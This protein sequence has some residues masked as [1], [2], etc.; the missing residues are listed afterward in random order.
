MGPPSRKLRGV[1]VVLLLAVLLVGGGAFA[2]AF[3]AP[4]PPQLVVREDAVTGWGCSECRLR[5]LGPAAAVV[6][7]GGSAAA[8][9]AAPFEVSKSLLLRTGARGRALFLLANKPADAS[10]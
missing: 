9:V 5:V 4:L 3:A 2:F 1:V 7:D 8:A 6:D 10:S